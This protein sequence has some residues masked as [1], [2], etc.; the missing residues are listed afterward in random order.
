MDIEKCDVT[1]IHEETIEKVKKDF[2]TKTTPILI[3]QIKE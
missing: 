1:V 3:K 2:H